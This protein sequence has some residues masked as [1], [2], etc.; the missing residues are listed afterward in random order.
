MKQLF[1]K[2]RSVLKFIATFL[3]V[4]AVLTFSY[5]MFLQYSSGN[6]YYPDYMTNLVAKQS[7]EILNAL[8]YRVQLL[9]HPKEASLKLIINEKYVARVIEGCNS[10]S[11]IILFISFIIAFS[12][13]FKTTVLYILAGSV[14]IYI[15]NLIRIVILSVGLYHYP[16]RKD[17]LHTVIFPAIIY[18]MVCLLW[19][20]WV[21]RFSNSKKVE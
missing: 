5:K 12:S 7:K 8:D 18:G 10:I 21:N 17:I 9:P 1:I 4:Y 13:K 20:V 3:I 15:A 11:I 19:V 16:W 14:L 2:Y 6:T